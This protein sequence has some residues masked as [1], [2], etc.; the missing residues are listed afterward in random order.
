MRFFACP[1]CG[2]RLYFENA[3]CLACHAEV[4]FRP[5]ASRFALP[6]RD[7]LATCANRHECGCNWTAEGD[8]PFC[9]AC[10]LNRTVPDMSVAGNRER[11]TK[12]EAAKRR[13][14][15]SLI[16]FG[17]DVSPKPDPDS[18]YGLAFDFIGDPIG[19]ET[20]E[21]VLTGH[22]NGLITLNVEEADD[23]R[24]EASRLAMGEAYRTLL[25]HFRHELGHYYWGLLIRDDTQW[26]DRYRSVFGDERADYAEALERHY[27][28]GAPADWPDHFISAYAA[29]HP[30]EDWAESWAHYLHIS[31]TL[32]TVSALDMWIGE[33][34]LSR[35]P[36]FDDLLAHWLVLT[37]AV[38]SINRSMGMSDLYPFVISE[39]VAEKLRFVHELL[40]QE[41][42]VV[43]QAG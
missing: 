29:S 9:E 22:D 10:V 2:N 31:D 14:I 4:A 15:Y 34:D 1:N 28:E 11:W 18:D 19:V 40:G 25:G 7:D 41:G 13:A 24:R 5:R 33:T 12:I 26:L 38:N 43:P 6:E 42:S 32:T 39:A 3:V 30:W 35:P 27:A 37:E 20:K 8:S 36:D 17:L 16:G 21:R 23:P